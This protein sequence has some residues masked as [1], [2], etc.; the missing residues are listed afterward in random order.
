MAKREQNRG[1]PGE[2]SACALQIKLN[3]KVCVL[4]EGVVN[5]LR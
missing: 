1:L 5:L 3:R 2:G 4:L